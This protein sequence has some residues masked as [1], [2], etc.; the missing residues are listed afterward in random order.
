MSRPSEEELAQEEEQVTN[1]DNEALDPLCADN[2][3]PSVR[4]T[5]P[6]QQYRQLADKLRKA[7]DEAQAAEFDKMAEQMEQRTVEK[8][9]IPKLLVKPRVDKKKQKESQNS[10]DLRKQKKTEEQMDR[11]GRARQAEEKAQRAMAENKK[12]R[13]SLIADKMEAL[14]CHPPTIF[15][16]ESNLVDKRLP[17]PAVDGLNLVKAPKQQQQCAM[18]PQCKLNIPQKDVVSHSMSCT[19]KPPEPA[20]AHKLQG[21]ATELPALTQLKKQTS[22]AK[23]TNQ[24][25][26]PGPLTRRC[27]ADA[28]EAERKKDNGVPNTD[29]LERKRHTEERRKRQKDD[30]NSI[31]RIG[32]KFAALK[33]QARTKN[34]LA[35]PSL[36]KHNT[37]NKERQRNRH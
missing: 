29:K 23:D 26:E 4:L 15:P 16:L 25:Y 13:K 30:E 24:R 20:P 10:R 5:T 12:R 34:D 2:P 36:A 3:P 21:A 32:T 14:Q 31:P 28:A 8:A 6:Q 11:E 17:L 37:H 33:G 19:A 1:A 35:I 9:H 27:L 7:G 22:P 18:C